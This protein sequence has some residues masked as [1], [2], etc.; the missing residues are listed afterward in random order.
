MNLVSWLCAAG[1]IILWASFATLVSHA[2]QVPPLLLTG[3]ALSLGSVTCLFR[4]REWRVPF[5]TMAF[6]TVCLFVYHVS[7][8]MAFRLAPIAEANLINYLWPLLLVLLGTSLRRGADCAA[9]IVGAMLGFGGCVV[10]IGSASGSLAFSMAHCVGYA[11]ALLAA[12]IWAVYS[13]GARW[14]PPFSSWAVG[15]FCLGAGVLAI[16][17]HLL[18]EPRF[19]PSGSDCLWM[20]AI[21]LGPL[22]IS[23]MLWDRALRQGNASQIGILAYG[24]PVL[25][26]LGLALAGQVTDRDWSTIFLASTLIVAGVAVASLGPVVLRQGPSVQS[27]SAERRSTDGRT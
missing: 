7:L 15:G 22:G 5:R 2:P 24:T 9:K 11:T 16:V 27:G 8:V 1:A 4:A 13:L 19:T 23:F 3:V 25:S 10:A 6:G 17:S 26:M 18:F 20:T 12:I 21:G 14:L